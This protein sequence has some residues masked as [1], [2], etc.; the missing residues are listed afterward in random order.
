[1]IFRLDYD[2]DIDKSVNMSRFWNQDDANNNELDGLYV[3]I[4]IFVFPFITNQQPVS[5]NGV[6]S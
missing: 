6:K 3:I 5:S 1:M 2:V 4:S